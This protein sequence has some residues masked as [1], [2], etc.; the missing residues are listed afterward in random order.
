M[1]EERVPDLPLGNGPTEVS[2][3]RNQTAERSDIADMLTQLEDPEGEARLSAGE[4][5]LRE[6]VFRGLND[7]KPVWDSPV[8]AHFNAGDFIRVVDRCTVLGVRIIGIE[9]FTT[10]GRLLDIE[11]SEADANSRCVS[12]VQ[13]YQERID[14]SIC[15]TYEVP[16]RILNMPPESL[17]L[18][19]TSR[20][21]CTCFVATAADDLNKKEGHWSLWPFLRGETPWVIRQSMVS[22][23]E[24]AKNPEK[25]LWFRTFLHRIA[26]QMARFAYPLCE[27]EEPIPANN[28]ILG[29]ESHAE[30]EA[31][32]RSFLMKNGVMIMPHPS[33]VPYRPW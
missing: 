18:D 1:D 33:E 4:S 9:I 2:V 10:E 29:P 26:N 19:Q 23:P 30:A 8:I 22:D 16:G 31:G 5:F 3:E 15:A 27:A 14:L 24:Q 28:V 7:L 12:F 11:I 13:K 6:F 25:I 32:T 17:M 20:P 21:C